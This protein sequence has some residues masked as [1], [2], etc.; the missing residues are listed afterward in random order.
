MIRINHKCAGGVAP[1]V[2]ILEFDYLILI[3]RF[4]FVYEDEDGDHKC[5]GCVAPG[6]LRLARVLPLVPWAQVV[7]G[8][9]HLVA[10]GDEKILMM[11]V[12]M[13][14]TMMMTMYLA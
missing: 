6:V 7:N 13:M 5:A 8:Q 2:V 12:I 9:G 10:T 11:K 1:G 4:I 3:V 14:V